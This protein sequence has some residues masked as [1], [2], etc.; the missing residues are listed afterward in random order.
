ME[1]MFFELF[2]LKIKLCICIKVKNLDGLNLLTPTHVEAVLTAV[3][4]MEMLWQELWDSVFMFL[5]EQ[6]SPW[7]LKA[8]AKWSCCRAISCL[9]DSCCLP[10]QNT[11][12]D[13]LKWQTASFSH[14]HDCSEAKQCWKPVPREGGSTGRGSCAV[15]EEVV[16]RT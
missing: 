11:C 5:Y 16:Y 2:S 4:W 3:Q 1:L 10:T 9:D 6:S 12:F 14:C 13:T 7:H 15:Y 8:S